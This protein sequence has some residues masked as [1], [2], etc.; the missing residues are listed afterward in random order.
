MESAGKR[1]IALAVEGG[2][3]IFTINQTCRNQRPYSSLR[4]SNSVLDQ[5]TRSERSIGFPVARRKTFPGE[6]FHVQFRKTWRADSR[7]TWG[8]VIEGACHGATV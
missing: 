2:I 6:I 4:V 8:N 7:V 5:P 1:E 3:E